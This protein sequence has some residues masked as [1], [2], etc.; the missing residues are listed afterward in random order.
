MVGV[1]V[2]VEAIVSNAG[3][4]VTGL[5]SAPP[6]EETVVEVVVATLVGIAMEVTVE[7]K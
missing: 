5:G 1:A 6:V 2:A 3:N 7:G 4:L